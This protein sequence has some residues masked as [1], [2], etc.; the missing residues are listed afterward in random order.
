MEGAGD[1]DARCHLSVI[2]LGGGG[3]GEQD[4]W[5]YSWFKGTKCS[6]NFV[7]G[8]LVDFLPPK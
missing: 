3:G 8:W 2:S 4:Y 7:G 1:M 6:K 5:K